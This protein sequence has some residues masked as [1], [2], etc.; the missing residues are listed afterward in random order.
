MAEKGTEAGKVDGFHD[1]FTN[2]YFH[3]VSCPAGNY[4]IATSNTQI[5]RGLNSYS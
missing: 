2:L 5:R 3:E 1:I 4:D